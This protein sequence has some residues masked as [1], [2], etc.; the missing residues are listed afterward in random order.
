VHKTLVLWGKCEIIVEN[1]MNT[2]SFIG[3]KV[4]KKEEFV[5]K[6]PIFTI[7]LQKIIFLGYNYIEGIFYLA[8]N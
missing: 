7:R 4:P 1:D 6:N 5:W 8:S 2:A 3:S